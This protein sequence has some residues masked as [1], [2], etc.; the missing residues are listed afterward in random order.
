MEAP[1]PK[2][3]VHLNVCREGMSG[4]GTMTGPGLVDSFENAAAVQVVLSS[5]GH[6]AYTRRVDQWLGPRFEHTQTTVVERV[7]F[8]CVKSG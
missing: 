2:E 4:K 3:P 7:S 6:G 8:P 5:A 1:F